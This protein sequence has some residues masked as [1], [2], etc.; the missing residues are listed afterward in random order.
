M[1]LVTSIVPL[2]KFQSQSDI[3]YGDANYYFDVD[4]A[5]NAKQFIEKSNERTSKI[6]YFLY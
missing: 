2:A 3:S 1:V 5:G 4:H 6:I